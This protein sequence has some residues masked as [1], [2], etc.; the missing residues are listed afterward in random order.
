MFLQECCLVR[1]SGL[2]RIILLDSKP[3]AIPMVARSDELAIKMNDLH[4]VSNYDGK[5]LMGLS[6]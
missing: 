4:K 5:T 2:N 6:Y 3:V 1:C